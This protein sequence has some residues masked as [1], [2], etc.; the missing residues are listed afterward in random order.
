M[1]QQQPSSIAEIKQIVEERDLT[2][3]KVGVIDMDGIMR[4]KYMSRN[5]LYSA[6]ENGFGFC[7]VVL[8]WDSKDQLYDNVQFTGWH[9]GYPDAT[10][11]LLP[12]TLRNLP[13]EGD[14]LFLL[15]EFSGR[16]ESICPRGC[17]R[18]VITQMQQMGYAAKA[19]IEYEFYIFEESSHSCREKNYR[20]MKPLEPGFFGYSMLRNSV[21]ADLYTGLLDLGEQ[22]NFRIE[23]LHEETGPG[24][25]EAAI[26]VDE[27]LSAADKAA[28]F[29]TFCKIYMQQQ[30]LMAT[31]MARW[32]TDWPG[33]SGH[34]HISL[35]DNDAQPVFYDANNEHCIS[36]CMRHFLAGQQHF[37][38][39]LLA[40]IA[41][42]VNSF[43]RLV[44]G[45]WAPTEASLGIDNRTCALRV[46][47]GSAKSL[48]SEYRI[49]AAD[50]NPYLA[51][52]AAL[53]SGL[54][55]I[56]Q[57]LEPT[58][59]VQGN[60]YEQSFPK[61]LA[62]PSTLFEAAQRLR[63]SKMARDWFG[64]DFVQHYAASREWEER[65]FRKAVTD[66]EMD[67]YFEII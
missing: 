17:L 1:T 53:A 44:P 64:D 25:M 21:H 9:T 41:P 30:G 11:R 19:G 29:K 12:D 35:T 18:N 62:L 33:S 22:M 6:L 48:R 26:E 49:S 37:M 50:A 61:H 32:S 54:E 7:E 65:E 4:G 3:I 14:G 24:V 52:A 28:M 42:T 27:A 47:P 46:V 59:F 13:M 43:R 40:M 66:W 55:G 51:L 20:D 5:K 39:E 57:K 63:K 31:F 15:G 34:M 56:R 45:F 58:P 8:G 38:P 16:A 2:H 10:V 23:A 36:T 60:A 67:R